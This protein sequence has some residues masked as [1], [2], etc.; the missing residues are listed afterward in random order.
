MA[1]ITQTAIKHQEESKQNLSLDVL[2]VAFPLSLMLATSGWTSAGCDLYLRETNPTTV[3]TL[4]SPAEYTLIPVAN[5]F[6]DA[7][8]SRQLALTR[9][10]TV[11]ELQGLTSKHQSQSAFSLEDQLIR[12]L[13]TSSPI[14]N[15]SESE[16]DSRSVHHFFKK[17]S[18]QLADLQQRV[19]PE[20]RLDIS[21]DIGQICMDIPP[22]STSPELP[23]DQVTTSKV[24]PLPP[25]QP[26]VLKQSPSLTT[27]S[28]L[29]ALPRQATWSLAQALDQA[30]Q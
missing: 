7:S 13:E 14:S 29:A 15:G 16:P 27:F 1:Q 23:S 26:Q 2:V 10:Q 6:S 11:R 25:Q 12:S 9:L 5:P 17:W 20:V 8:V 30:A 4:S 3:D 18:T 22:A 24:F 21:A 28:D 19:H